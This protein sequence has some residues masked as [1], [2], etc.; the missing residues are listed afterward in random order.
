IKDEKSGKSFGSIAAHPA[1]LVI[2]GF[3]F[4]G[5]FG[6]VIT[7]QWQKKEWD[8]QQGRLLQ[9]RRIEQ[10]EKIMES[11][12]QTIAENCATTEDVLIAFGSE[13]RVGEPDREDITKDR[14]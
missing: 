13:W 6:T 5:I 14:I 2:V 12:T 4:T 10:K 3:I 8:R 7:S 11:L 9:I 1:T